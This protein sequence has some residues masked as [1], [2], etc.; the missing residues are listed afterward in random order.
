MSINETKYLFCARAI[1]WA[2]R[3]SIMLLPMLTGCTVASVPGATMQATS[4]DYAE[5]RSVDGAELYLQVRAADSSDPVLLWLHGGPG[6]AE[7]PLFR[8]YNSDLENHFV[9]VYWDQRGTGR[10]FDDRADPGQLTIA[11]HL[12][13]LD[14]VVKH[15]TRTF[16][17]DKIILVGH[18]WGSALGMLYA[19][20]HPDK[21]STFIG[22]NPVVSTR[23]AQAAEYAFV[24]QRAIERRDEK[25]L[26]R[27]QEIGAPPF[28]DSTE[29]LDVEALVDKYGGLFHNR[30]NRLWV[31]LRGIFSGLVT[32]GEI[33][34]FIRANDIS[35]NAMHP[36]LLELDL[37]R[38]VPNVDVPVVF[39]LGEY[40][41][42]ADAGLAAAYFER[43][44]AA[45][46][47][48]I[49]FDRSAHNIPFE[50]PA[51]FNA[52]CV[53][54]LQALGVLHGSDPSTPGSPARNSKFN[55]ANHP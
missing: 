17:Q 39:F 7:R 12:A 29:V 55:N 28:E 30:P 9:V 25:T 21:V 54:E 1:H 23:K 2:L 11:R 22:V 10:S 49:W 34:A 26:Q 50:E 20:E 46:K 36:E 40:D 43:L 14:A 42:H 51:R 18:S 8:Y 52:T 33:P 24:Q 3:L 44:N 38:D 32:P 19:H 35:L 45:V 16:S 47:R 37:A 48:L 6:G 53:T 5:Y 15:L 13:D 4:L 27:L 31:M 41:R